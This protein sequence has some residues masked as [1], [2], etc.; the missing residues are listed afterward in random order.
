MTT[1]SMMLRRT[2][3]MAA[4]MICAAVL[5]AGSAAAGVPDGDLGP[6]VVVFDLP[7]TY[8]WGTDGTVRAYSVGTTSCNRGDAPLSWIFQYEP[9]PGDRPEPL[10]G[11]AGR[12][13]RRSTARSKCSGCRGSSTDSCPSTR[14]RATPAEPPRGIAARR[15]LL[16]PLLRQ[17]Q[18]QPEPSRSALGGQRLHRVFRLSPPDPSGNPT[19]A[20]RLQVERLGDHQRPDHLLAILSRASTAPM[21]PVGRRRQPGRTTA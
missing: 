10:S 4:V 14:A 18:R 17:P 16:R 13:R 6:D 11:D 1:K 2:K 21:T 3:L 5:A 9:A 19:V 15:R 7:S 20:G 12:S 8:N